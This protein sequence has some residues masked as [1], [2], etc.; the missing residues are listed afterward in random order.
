MMTSIH[1]FFQ[2][3]HP[4]IPILHWPRFRDQYVLVDAGDRYTNLDQESAFLIYAMASLSARYSTSPYFDDTILKEREFSFV[5]RANALYDSIANSS[6]PQRPSLI[7]LQGC[8]LLAYYKQAMNPNWTGDMLTTR[9]RELAYA[10]EL[11]KIDE[12]PPKDVQANQ[13]PPKEDWIAKEE[14]RRAW[15]SVWELETFD[16]MA[17][18][19]LAT[20]RYHEVSV[21]LPVSDAAWFANEPVA[22]ACLDPNPLLAWK[23]LKNSAN[24]DPRAWFLIGNDIMSRCHQIGLRKLVTDKETDDM[25]MVISCFMLLLRDRFSTSGKQL[26]F[27]ERNYS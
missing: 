10:L 27:D 11:N 22:S 23:S 24:D 9:C 1:L 13:Q 15:W 25:E 20:R 5:R 12:Q 8:I 19:R 4:Y 6:T 18:R 14:R 7:W 16:C 2:R 26:F 3:V 17:S 21:F